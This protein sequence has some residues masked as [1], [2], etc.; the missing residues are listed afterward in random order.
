MPYLK[1]AS[2]R[3]LLY[4]ENL[5]AGMTKKQAALAAGY[6]LTTAYNARR[7]IETQPKVQ[8]LALKKFGAKSL[9]SQIVFCIMEGMEA[10]KV[11]PNRTMLVEKQGDEYVILGIRHGFVVHPDHRTRYRDL[12]QIMKILGY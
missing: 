9:V 12:R 1:K 7:A 2:R 8:M 6:A 5:N 10:T 11:V 3:S 4:L